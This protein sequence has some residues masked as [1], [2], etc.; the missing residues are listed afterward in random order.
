MG[1]EPMTSVIPVWCSTNWA[2]K[3]QREQVKSSICTRYMKVIIMI[4]HNVLSYMIFFTLKL[5]WSSQLWSNLNSCKESPEKNL[6]LQQGFLLRLPVEA[7]DI[8]LGFLC[9]C[10]SCFET[11]RITYTSIFYSQFLV[12]CHSHNWEKL[13]DHSRLVGWPT[14]ADHGQPWMVCWP[15]VTDCDWPWTVSWPTMADHEW[16]A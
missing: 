3:P 10:L 5:T 8:F 14:V 13:A 6:R 11:V 12:V 7:S 1:F 15:T 2:M 4:I 16:S 9:N